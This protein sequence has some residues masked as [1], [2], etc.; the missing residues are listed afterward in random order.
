MGLGFQCLSTKEKK[1]ET[2]QMHND[3]LPNKITFFF[4]FFI[5]AFLFDA[6]SEVFLFCMLRDGG[7]EP[8]LSS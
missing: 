8:W 3:M 2:Q 4:F 5:S 1:E 6:G 7:F